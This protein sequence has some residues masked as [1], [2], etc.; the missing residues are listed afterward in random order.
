MK[1]NYLKHTLNLLSD[2]LIR[3][4]FTTDFEIAEKKNHNFIPLINNLL[5]IKNSETAL[6]ILVLKF[7]LK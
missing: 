1:H 2:K 6:K 4:K 7:K 3:I 5:N